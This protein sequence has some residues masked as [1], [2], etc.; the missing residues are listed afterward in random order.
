[1]IRKA[2]RAC[3]GY[4][5]VELGGVRH[6]FVAA[7]PPRQG[8]SF[9]QQA[10]DVLGSIEGL[11]KGES[12]QASIVM[13]SV[14]LGNSADE[15]ECRAIM[16]DFYGADMPATTYIW[17][18]PCDGALLAVEA[19][20]VGR[21]QAQGELEIVRHGDDTVIVRHGGIAWAHVG[22]VRCKPAAVY[23]EATGA[24]R[25]SAARLESAGFRFEEV[26]RTWLYLGDITGLESRQTRYAELNRARADYYR[27]LTFAA[28]SEQSGS[29]KPVFPASTGIGADGKAVTVGCMAMRSER[30][31]VSA[32]AIENPRQTA[33]YD[34]AHQYGS[35]SPKFCR[36]MAVAAGDFAAIFISGTASITASETQHLED[37][38]AQTAQTLDNIE[39]LI[40]EDNLVGHG[41]AGFGSSLADL[42][43]GRVYI[44]RR[45]DYALARA[46]CEKRLGDV[47][48]IYAV[49]DI[50]RAELLVEIEGIAFSQRK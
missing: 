23:D 6:F 42:A 35:E 24:F 41:L 33:A 43:L 8:A 19:M 17:Q 15:A 28:V 2:S 36:A 49:G 50:C 29:D 37:I 46:V 11:I 48:V 38:R 26:I 7:A 47:P 22:G 16:R 40:A 3:T 13:Q 5:V 31:G 44:K 20:G 39:G 32:V 30:P 12:A 10:H 45:E 14:F 27:D 21:A 9:R 4:S 25:L 34:Y 18:P 1:M